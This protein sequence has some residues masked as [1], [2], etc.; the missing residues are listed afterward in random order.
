[1]RNPNRC[2]WRRRLLHGVG[3]HTHPPRRPRRPLVA[4]LEY[5]RC[6]RPGALGPQTMEARVCTRVPSLLL[7]VFITAML[8]S[9]CRQTDGV[10][11]P[12]RPKH[13]VRTAGTSPAGS[14]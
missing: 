1:V 4:E 7:L 11:L 9:L 2:L 5:L 3:V 10:C 8:T 14:G 13:Y 12:L 6:L